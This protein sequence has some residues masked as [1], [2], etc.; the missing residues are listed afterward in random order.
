[1][2][3]DA[4][5]EFAAHRLDSGAAMSHCTGM[6]RMTAKFPG[7]CSACSKAIAE[8]DAIDYDRSTRRVTCEACAG[9]AA[10]PAPTMVRVTVT[11][12]AMVV[13][14]DGRVT[15][16]T[17]A[18]FRAALGQARFKDGSNYVPTSR[19]AEVLSALAG[20]GLALDVSSDARTA[21]EAQ[22][23]SA[24][25]SLAGA[26]ERTAAVD[27]ILAERGGGLYPYQREGAVWLAPRGAALVAD[28]MGL[29]KTI[30][31]LVAAPAG[32]PL[33]VVCPAV[34]KGVWEQEASR[35]RPDLRVEALEGRGSF[36]APAPGELLVV[37]YDILPAT[38]EEI[39][40]N[41]V[42]GRT[43]QPIP[44]LAPGTVVIL[45]EAHAVASSKSQR[46]ERCRALCKAARASGGRSWALTATPMKNRPQEIWNVLRCV[47]LESEAYGSWN[48]FVA[49]YNGEKGRWGGYE[50]GT[51]RPEAAAG[52]RRVSL[53]RR[54][55][56]VLT[57]L[58]AKT[59]REIRADI[60]RATA[61]ACDEALEQIAQAAK[62]D[63]L[64][65]AC[66]RCNSAP[67]SMCRR[68]DAGGALRRA[69]NERYAAAR[70]QPV[71]MRAIGDML[72]APLAFESISEVRAALAQAKIPAML[73]MVESYEAQSEPLVVFSAFRAPVDL[74]AQ[75]EGWAAIAG[76]TSNEERTE[77]VRRFQAGEL[78]GVACTIRAG[79]V[80]ITLTR[81]SN[82]LRVDREWNPAL[83]VQ[84]EDRC[85]RIGQR[86]AVL[87]TD[88]VAQHPLDRIIAHCLARKERLI[89]ASVDAASV[90]HAEAKEPVKVDFEAIERQ[91]AEAARE[92]VAAQE[93]GKRARDAHQKWLAEARAAAALAGAQ[94]R[95]RFAAG[96]RLGE[97][98]APEDAP[99]RGPVGAVEH[100]AIDGL[101]RLA[102]MDPDR[103]QEINNIGFSKA[104]NSLSHALAT[105][106]DLTDQEWRLAISIARRYHRQI[107]NAPQEAA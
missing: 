40:R 100:W 16:E 59:Y 69:H 36:R 78:R 39:G 106:G 56:D 30:Q 76:D 26:A 71:A 38:T 4:Q 6:A 77:I 29:G 103:A 7:K 48:R 63:P 93:E 91:A 73:E 31:T 96:L 19:G 94:A 5:H 62:V 45:D 80:A 65:V 21:I 34:A 55:A 107:G 53:R 28:D 84:A 99:R 64:S 68:P 27:A 12:G 104:D 2:R 61:K 24:Q 10:P 33:L 58:P 35:W 105:I 25:A 41:P 90:V 22:Q 83:N 102:A 43:M 89:G 54:K 15:P 79:G 46:T 37:N 18:A 85:Y 9:P 17:F 87:V 1:M 60:D 88:L 74:L 47:G 95:V 92:L 11:D 23:A 101:Q 52:L 57:D 82:V 70:E 42:K 97:E 49:A 51:P 8:G 13:R 66:P 72:D 67:R 32:A 20:I 81:A 44:E 3:G 50:W 14:L 75:R 86:S 98:Q